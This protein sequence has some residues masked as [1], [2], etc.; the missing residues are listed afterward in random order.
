M[1]RIHVLYKVYVYLMQE[2][3]EMDYTFSDLKKTDFN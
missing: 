2:V 3:N 1:S